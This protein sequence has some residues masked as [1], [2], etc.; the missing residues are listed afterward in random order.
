MKIETEKVIKM[1]IKLSIKHWKRYGF[2]DEDEIVNVVM[3][4]YRIEELDELR[5]GVL[6]DAQMGLPAA[7]A[8]LVGIDK[9]L[10]ELKGLD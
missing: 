2:V 4:Q 10:I 1:G 3:K 7:R 5:V 9:Q 6:K 8:A